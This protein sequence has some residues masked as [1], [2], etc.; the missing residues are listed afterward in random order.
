M[1]VMNNEVPS[2]SLKY[3]NPFR[4]LVLI[5]QSQAQISVPNGKCYKEYTKTINF[6]RSKDVQSILLARDKDGT[7]LP[8]FDDLAVLLVSSPTGVTKCLNINRWQTD[9]D[10]H[11]CPVVTLSQ[12]I[13]D[14]IL[15]MIDVTEYF[16]NEYGK[17]SVTLSVY[18]KFT[19]IAWSTC[20]LIPN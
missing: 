11:D 5:S 3:K 9:C 2:L 10:K 12:G 18:D 4:P 17:F 1:M 20:W 16:N 6:C 7:Y 8:Y 14:L 19:P 13:N 15:G